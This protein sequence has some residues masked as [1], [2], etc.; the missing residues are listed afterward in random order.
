[1]RHAKAHLQKHQGFEARSLVDTP[2]AFPMPPSPPD[3]DSENLARRILLSNESPI[4]VN[5]LASLRALNKEIRKRGGEEV[6][7]SVFR[8]NIVLDSTTPQAESSS[9]A[10]DRWSGLRIGGQHFKMLG[11][12]RRC[13][14]VCIN[15]ETGEKNEEPF[16]T[17]SKTRRFDGKVFF[18]TH[19][20][21]DVL[22]QTLSTRETQFPTIMVGD[23]VEVDT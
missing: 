2:A 14:M 15:Q 21:H 23:A 22:S 10:E 13:Y 19:M 16:V 7:S 12:C 3:S 4:L 18:G 11:S 6:P 17:L 9:Y 8:A 1:M 5:N 20:G